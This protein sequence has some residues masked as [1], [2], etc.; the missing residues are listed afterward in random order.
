[1]AAQSRGAV[2][3]A[4]VMGDACLIGPQ[5]SWE[6]FRFL[7]REYRDAVSELGQGAKG[8]LAANRSLA[9][10]RDRETAITEARVAGEAKAGM[11]S[12]FNMQES[13]TVDLGLGS[14]R[15]LGDWA[16]A[17][18]PQDCAETIIRQ[19]EE[20]GLDYIGLACLNMPKGLS[21]RLEYLQLI[22]EELLPRLP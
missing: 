21:A 11:Y 1:M 17:G 20:F 22:S 5:P 14:S 19:H 7:A 13:T 9:I 12:S 10:A 18:S 2:R 6:N 15:D 3:R 16:I 4:A 8:F